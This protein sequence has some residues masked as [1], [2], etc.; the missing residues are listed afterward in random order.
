[1]SLR[2]ATTA[3]IQ[4]DLQMAAC[5][6]TSIRTQQWLEQGLV[7]VVIDLKAEVMLAQYMLIT[8]RQLHFSAVNRALHI[9]C[10]TVRR[11]ST[12]SDYGRVHDITTCIPSIPMSR[13]IRA[14]S[15]KIN[16]RSTEKYKIAVFGNSGMVASRVVRGCRGEPGG[17][18]RADRCTNMIRR[19]AFITR[20]S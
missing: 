8:L 14:P 4:P 12:P 15:L 9:L 17:W 18:R 7:E 3:S 5:D 13:T 19:C 16:G 20:Q 2:G 1:M 10:V 11:G 6:L